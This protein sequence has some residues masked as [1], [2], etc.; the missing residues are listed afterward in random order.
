MTAPGF[1]S[2]TAA[3][4]TMVLPSNLRVP[5]AMASGMGHSKGKRLSPRHPPSVAKM[6]ALAQYAT[7]EMAGRDL[8]LPG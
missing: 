8:V 4:A 1:T 7:L 2:P 5:I 3:F 6:F